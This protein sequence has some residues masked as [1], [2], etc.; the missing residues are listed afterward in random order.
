MAAL[1]VGATGTAPLGYQWFAGPSG[2]TSSPVVG[3]TSSSYT[4]PA[5]TETSRFWVR[6]SNTLGTAD[7]IDAL[8]TVTAEPPEPSFEDEVLELV[9]ERRA[10]GATCGGTWFPPVS[11]L[12]MN[13]NLRAAARGHSQDMATNNYFSHTSLDG[14]TFDQRMRDAGYDGPFPWGENIAA[15]RSTPESVMGSWM[16]S[17]GHCANIMKAGFRVIGV[18]YA[19]REGSQYR[20][21]WTQDFG[22][23]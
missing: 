14:R 3:A 6:V 9:N 4:T 22:G 13:E 10:A 20:H 21:Y 8:I 23:G 7:S 11:A 2:T 1:A 12:T 17:S 5:L 18:G 15:G 16:G 19:F